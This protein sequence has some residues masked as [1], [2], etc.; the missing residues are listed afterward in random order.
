MMQPESTP[1][2]S[3]VTSAVRQVDLIDAVR[4]RW[5][6]IAT[7]GALGVAVA[8]LY[9]QTAVR[10]YQ[11]NI[12]VLVGRRSSETTTTGTVSGNANGD[13]LHHDE[14]ATHLRLFAAP[15]V[16][17]AAIRDGELAAFP[18]FEATRA[19]GGSMV[20]Y[21]AKNLTVDRGGEGGSVGA[22]VLTA[23]FESNDPEEAA[24]V[25]SAVYGSYRDYTSNQGDDDAGL[26]VELIESAGRVHEQ[27]LRQAEARYQAFVAEMP[28]LLGGPDPDEIH[29][30]RLTKLETELSAVRSKVSEAK[31]RLQVIESQ[32]SRGDNAGDATDLGRLA[33]LSQK[34]MDRLRF[35]LDVSRGGTNT[36]AFQAEQPL[37]AEAARAN[38]NRLL[39]LIQKE[40]SFTETFGEGH[41]MV[42]SIRREVEVT[43]RFLADHQ[44]ETDRP[45]QTEMTAAEMIRTYVQLLRHDIAESEH[46]QLELVRQSRKEMAL[47][48]SVEAD[49]L[50]A[51]SLQKAI[52]RARERY[53]N[54][55]NRLQELNL[56]RS[57]VGLN[58][59]LLAPPVVADKPSWP[60]TPLILFLG[61][62][63]GC[64]L[65]LVLALAAELFDTTF[66]GIED[67][68]A[69]T[70]SNVLAH[71]PRM[72]PRKMRSAVADGSVL[73][74]ALVAHH[75]PRGSVAEV[76]RV[77]RTA[78]MLSAKKEGCRTLMMT[79][80]QPG[81]GKSTTI[82]NLAISIAG[83]SKRVLL[84]DADL[85][86][87][88]MSKVF[89][90]G[91]HAG[92][93]DAL[94]G[95]AGLK[96]CISETEV[97]GLHLMPHGSRT[98]EPAELLDSVSMASLLQRL[99]QHYDLILIDAPP[100]LAVTDPA[101]LAASVDAV[102][103][104]VRVV[105]NGRRIVEDAV[106]ILDDVD[107]TPI[108]V[109]VNGVDKSALGSYADGY[110]REPYGY[111]GKYHDQYAAGNV[112]GP[113]TSRRRGVAKPAV[114]P[115]TVDTPARRSA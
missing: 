21:L 82:S 92:L 66:A 9:C 101:V 88:T 104:T 35:F 80:P 90:I 107:V 72:S 20:D 52:T 27:E 26:A 43:R 53:T 29:R 98:D 17:E 24:A 13:N 16:L 22:M 2:S 46:Q 93:S 99:R 10:R 23:A 87:P 73:A 75:D 78:L 97:P 6:L 37:R 47:A 42:E 48:K 28:V 11:S 59:D 55:V 69:T 79:S 18:G 58:T 115:E 102:M 31:S 61:A 65:G 45:T 1:S 7:A 113:K 3:A 41:P 56:S 44:P 30:E 32:A 14:L 111:V 60:R 33:L 86:R 64:G 94:T 15:K 25:L 84:I 63:G 39:D 5:R 57:Y 54:V 4:K 112:P 38:Y 100:V 106:R 76:Y 50:K 114:A 109:F 81:D 83:T 40:Q 91:P 95:D 89:G 67:L 62:C 12:E 34:E 49:L 68:E 105:K 96:G 85:R 71:I 8:A 103:L 51:E 110:R 70:R 36:Q 77:G 108:G 74:P 19:A